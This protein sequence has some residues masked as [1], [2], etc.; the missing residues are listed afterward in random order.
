MMNLLRRVASLPGLRVALLQPRVRRTIASV[1]ALRFLRAAA[2]TRS[3]ARFVLAELVTSRGCIRS[4]PLRGGGTIT[5][6]HGRDLEAFHELMVAGEYEPPAELRARLAAPARILDRGGNIGRFAHWANRRWP[7]ALITS[8]EPDPDNLK[9]F[10]AGLDPELPVVLVE[11]AAMTR[12]GHAVLGTGSGAGRSVELAREPVPGS[13]P[14]VDIYEHLGSA[15]LVKMDIEGGEWPIL[16]D[17]RLAELR[18]LTWVIE[19]HR[20]GA[21]SLPAHDAAKTLFEQAG[22]TVGHAHR[23]HW[24]HGTLWAW[25]D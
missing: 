22:F 10:R 17:P 20:N 18:H 7:E 21:P 5:L 9:V 4:W 13:M 2:L 12:S 6:M 16:G 14:A 1:L 24:G 19:F 11:A 15:D 3:P 23:N 8:F 25:K